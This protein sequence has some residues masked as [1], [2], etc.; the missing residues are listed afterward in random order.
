M[1]TTEAEQYQYIK[2]KIEANA[3]LDA[4]QIQWIPLDLRDTLKKYYNH[5]NNLVK[6]LQV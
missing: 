4:S 5:A 3:L 6:E 1:K 2:L